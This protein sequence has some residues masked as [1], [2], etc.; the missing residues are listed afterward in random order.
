M[1]TRTSS[2]AWQ[3]EELGRCEFLLSEPCELLLPD[4]MTVALAMPE[5]YAQR[6]KEDLLADNANLDLPFTSRVKSV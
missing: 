2:S 3:P 6:R 1:L 4:F 5:L